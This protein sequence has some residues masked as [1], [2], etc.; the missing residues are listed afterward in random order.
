MIKNN[1]VLIVTIIFFAFI[2][3][4]STIVIAS[5]ID[6]PNSYRPSSDIGDVSGVTDKANIV[7]G[8]ITTIGIVVSV[9][10]LLILGIKYMLGSVSEKAEYKKSMIPYIIG[11]A[12]LLSVSTIVS[13]IAKLT[14]ETIK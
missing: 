3:L 2:M 13:I 6:D 10:T 5:P 9:I 4:A 14:G 12:L 1:R 7:I 11:V 8:T